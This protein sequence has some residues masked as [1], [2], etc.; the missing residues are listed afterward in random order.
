M[1]LLQYNKMY[2]NEG[3]LG[4][5]NI[6]EPGISW[7]CVIIGSQSRLIRTVMLALYSSIILLLYSD[8]VSPAKSGTYKLNKQKKKINFIHGFLLGTRNLR[9]RS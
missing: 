4:F 3:Y 9:R 2:K 6:E 5:L 1:E 8:K 7:I